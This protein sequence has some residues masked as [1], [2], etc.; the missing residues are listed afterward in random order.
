[1]VKDTAFDALL[2]LLMKYWPEDFGGL[3]MEKV[4]MAGRS[5]D[6]DFAEMQTR[7][8]GHYSEPGHIQELAVGDV[9][10]EAGV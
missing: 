1:M 5:Q 3:L 10:E 4:V 8:E 6:T 7:A 2:R 9:D